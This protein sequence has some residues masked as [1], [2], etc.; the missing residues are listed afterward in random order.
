MKIEFRLPIHVV[1]ALLIISS[2]ADRGFCVDNTAERGVN[3][4]FTTDWFTKNIPSWNRILGEM[5]DKPGLTYLEIGVWEGRSF[6]WVLDNILTHPSSRAVAMDL[7]L[8]DEEQ[9][10]LDN[11]A[12]SGHSSKVSVI[13]GSSQQKLRL[14]ELNSIDLIYIDGDHKS[15]GVL[16]DVILSWD[17]LKEGGILIFDD[18]K[19]PSDLP[20]EMRPEFAIDVFIDLF[21]DEIQIL[22][23]EY[24]L[25]VRKAK[26][27]CN[28]AMGFIERWDARIACSPLGPYRYYWKPQKL[29]DATTNREITLEDGDVSIIENTLLNLK[30][31]TEIEVEKMQMDRYTNLLNRLGVKGINVSLKE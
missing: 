29:Y 23:N 27:H 18:Y 30:F 8:G 12:R 10:F 31:G 13:K 6:F 19:F 20:R 21:Q 26:T 28:P 7:F 3:Y 1:L 25:I 5:K 11:L 4:T 17:L 2:T 9:V 14:L 15:R 16:M 24:Q 22:H